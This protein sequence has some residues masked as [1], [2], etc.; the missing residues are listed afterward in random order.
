MNFHVKCVFLVV[1][2]LATAL[3]AQ[4]EDVTKTQPPSPQEVQSSQQPAPQKEQQG[5]ESGQKPAPEK[6][7]EEEEGPQQFVP[8]KVEPIER[9]KP[10]LDAIVPQDAKIEKLAGGFK[11]TEGPIWTRGGY[12]LFSNMPDG[13]DKWMPDGKVNPFPS[14]QDTGGAP[15][16]SITSTN[17]LTLDPQGR[18]VM[19]D[20]SG[21]RIL[22][23]ENNWTLSVLADRYEGKRFNSPNDLVYKSDGSLYFTD[24]P[25]GLARQDDDPAK[26]LPF[27]G[28]Y[29]LAGG[30][31]QLLY[32][33]LSRPNGLAFSPDEKYLYVANSDAS[34]A[35]WVR[36][37][38][39]PD[40]TLGDGTVF[41]DVTGN[42]REGLPDGMKVD[43][44]GNVYA[45]GPGGIWIFSPQGEHLG[46]IRPPEIPAN[47]NWGDEDGKTLYLTARTGLY[48]IR[49]QI[50][51][52]RP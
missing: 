14:S 45:T 51:G 8:E 5:E 22:R 31:V 2:F 15:V 40:G 46:T 7:K 48:R 10:A 3:G 49:L 17:G 26:E 43:Q 9:L 23:L 52:I 42:S 12:L 38:V 16:P 24:P 19:A 1:V 13:I 41:Y 25:Y 6:E 36:F 35:M 29:R 20:Q 33:R 4:D 27:S 34:R 18:L 28:I 30:K 11:F 37:P 21:R 47:C 32:D 44:E 39:K 50:R